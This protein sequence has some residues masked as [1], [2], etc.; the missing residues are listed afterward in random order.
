[1]ALSLSLPAQAQDTAPGTEWWRGT[2]TAQVE[3]D[4]FWGTGDGHYT[5]GLR[6]S[7]ISPEHDTPPWWRWWSARVPFLAQASRARTGLAIGQ[8]MYTPDDIRV[9]GLIEDDRPYAGWLYGSYGVNVE[10]D[11]RILDSAALALGVVGPASGAEDVQKWFHD[12]IETVPPEGWDNQLENEP[13][14]VVSFE[15][16]VRQWQQFDGDLPLELDLTPHGGF[17]LGN[18][19]THLNAGATLRLGRGLKSDYGAP[20]IGSNLTGTEFFKPQRTWVFYGFAGV[21]ARL[22]GRN[23]FLDGNSFTDSHSVDRELLVGDLQVGFVLA[24]EALRFT[25]TYVYR[26]QEFEGQDDPDR[27]GAFSLSTNF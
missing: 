10:K 24:R 27:F 22:V 13:G 7:W 2:Y 16:R 20:R 4:V 5:N 6:L 14:V 9:R 21:E 15:R 19:F 12:V 23:I 17:S 26:T 1:L 11:E 25:F 3:N 18:I 8:N